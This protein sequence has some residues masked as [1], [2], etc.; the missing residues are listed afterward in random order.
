MTT[1]EKNFIGLDR[2]RQLWQLLGELTAI[3]D[4][5]GVTTV[6]PHMVTLGASAS[7]VIPAGAKGWAMTIF[8]GTGTVG[9]AAV[10]AGFAIDNPKTLAITLTVTTDAA[11]SGFVIWYT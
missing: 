10:G 7:Q 5:L 9:G 1:D 4:G 6:T 8:T 3:S 2:D 11:S